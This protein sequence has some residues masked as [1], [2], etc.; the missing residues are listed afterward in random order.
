MHAFSTAVLCLS[1]SAPCAAQLVP[2]EVQESGD[3]VAERL[4]TEARAL[5]PE[6][7]RI[8]V[9]AQDGRVYKWNVDL[10]DTMDYATLAKEIESSDED[11]GEIT[12]AVIPD[13]GGW[14]TGEALTGW[15][16]I[17]NTGS[18]RVQLPTLWGDPLI[19]TDPTGKVAEPI[20]FNG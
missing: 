13:R 6:G 11:G 17:T 10:S 3:L 16:T 2:H 5:V 9:F 18:A 7:C 14:K 4:R 15:L 1:L 12:V 19:A 20:F 8:G